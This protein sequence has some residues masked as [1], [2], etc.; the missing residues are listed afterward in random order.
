MQRGALHQGLIH[1]GVREFKDLELHM[2][3]NSGAGREEVGVILFQ[4]AT[5]RQLR[6]NGSAPIKNSTALESLLNVSSSSVSL[7]TSTQVSTVLERTSRTALTPSTMKSSFSS[8]S[9]STNATANTSSIDIPNAHLVALFEFEGA[10]IPKYN[11][12]ACICEGMV[13]LAEF[14]RSE[15]ITGIATIE[16]GERTIELQFRPWNELSQ[17]LPEDTVYLLGMISK[18]MYAKN[19]FQEGTFVLEKDGV[20]M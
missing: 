15:P 20:P 17:L 5:P 8:Y 7:P 9:T 16:S 6:I 19:K 11:V 1:T 14:P 4:N 2:F 13:A 10:R 3:W 18:Y 12:F